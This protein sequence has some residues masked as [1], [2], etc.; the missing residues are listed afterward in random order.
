MFCQSSAA[1]AKMSN[2]PIH[3]LKND[4]QNDDL[5]NFYHVL[6][7]LTCFYVFSHV[8]LW[9]T[10]GNIEKFPEKCGVGVLSHVSLPKLIPLAHCAKDMCSKY[11]KLQCFSPLLS[12]TIFGGEK[13]LRPF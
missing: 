11:T 5:K 2:I 6:V 1:S 7:I 10:P 13:Q 12:V 3:P 9:V 8:I 4:A